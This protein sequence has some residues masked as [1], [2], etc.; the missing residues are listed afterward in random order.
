MSSTTHGSSTKTLHTMSA[1][2]LLGEV[3]IVS[4]RASSSNKEVDIKITFGGGYKSH[5]KSSYTNYSYSVD[6]KIDGFSTRSLT[7]YSGTSGSTMTTS[8]W[9]DTG[10]SGSLPKS[11]TTVYTYKSASTTVTSSGWTSGSKSVSVIFYESG[12][13]VASSTFDLT[14]PT[15]S[16]S[17]GGGG[18]TT[19][20]ANTMSISISPSSVSLGNSATISITS[21]AGTRNGISKYIIYEGS[22]QLGS[23]TSTTYTVTPSST[24]TKTYKVKAV[25]TV[26]TSYDI[27]KSINLSVTT[28]N[29]SPI[30]YLSVGSVDG[31]ISGA[32]DV[33]VYVTK[34]STYWAYSVGSSSGAKTVVTSRNYS[35]ITA[36]ANQTIYVYGCELVNGTY[37]YST[38]V[39]GKVGVTYYVTDV[40]STIAPKILKDNISSPDLVTLIQR[41]QASAR[42]GGG[43]LSYTWEYAQSSTSSGLSNPT[44]LDLGV[45][46]SSFTNLDMTQK[47]NKGY[48]YKIRVKATNSYDN[49]EYSSDS[50]IYQIP[51]E[52]SR[53]TF[54][55]II[56]K[57][58]PSKGYTEI[59]QDNKKFYGSGLFILWTNPTILDSQLPISEIEMIYQSKSQS[60]TIYDE[61]KTAQFQYHKLLEEGKTEPEYYPLSNASGASNGGG[62]DLEV[63]SLYETK[64][65]IRITDTLGQ[66]IDTFYTTETFFK[67]ESPSFG[68]NL[69]VSLNDTGNPKDTVATFRPFTC[70][71]SKS[72][73]LSSSVAQSNSQ[74]SLLYFIDCYVNDRKT[75]I[76]LLDGIPIATSAFTDD[77]KPSGEILYS[78]E[79]IKIKKYNSTTI[80]YEINNSYFKNKLLSSAELRTPKNNSAAVYNDDFLEVIY[81]ISV[82]DDFDSRSTVY[83][84]ANTNIKYIEAPTLSNNSYLDIGVN[85]YIKSQNPF[86]DNSIVLLNSSSNNNDRMIN[87]GESIIFK[88]KRAQDYNG[89]DYSSTMLGD[90]TQYNIYVSRNDSIVTSNYENLTYTLLKSFSA[91]NNL[92]KAY[93]ND[94]TDEYYYLEY[95]LTN[96]MESK[97]VV[98][99]IE[100]VDSKSQKSD[101]LYSNTYIVPCRASSMDFYLSN[102]K[103][104]E[105]L[106]G[107]DLTFK[108]KV[109]DFG[110][111]FFVN[112][113]YGY[114]KTNKNYSFPNYERSFTVNSNTFS[115]K[116]YLIFEGCLDGDFSN[117]GTT[118]IKSTGENNTEIDNLYNNYFS[119]TIDLTSFLTNE[120][121]YTDIIENTYSASDFPTEWQTGIKNSIIKKIFFRLTYKIAYGFADIE[122]DTFD[123]RYLFVS[124]TCAPYS[125]YEDAPTVS[126][127]NHQ[128]GINT[129]DFSIDSEGGQKEVLIIQDNGSYNLVVFKGAEQKII[130]NLTERTFYTEDN[131]G[132]V[133]TEI[134]FNTQYINGMTIDSGEW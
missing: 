63:N 68:G 79:N 23:T 37:Y 120:N 99:K 125:Y 129:K 73:L 13:Q 39:N 121:C 115:R 19:I 103:L 130:L 8:S 131:S 61:I 77:T 41:G 10:S 108:S 59:I 1:N 116:G 97:F 87:P 127:R 4:T 95:P 69:V 78:D 34:S 32:Q 58:D 90:V 40:S 132:K 91:L 54:T 83:N 74:D 111:S 100:A 66:Y 11:G 85:R 110:A 75:T 106:T 94:S 114:D 62:A 43:S 33:F 124:S 47:V 30:S 17:G 42:T 31:S 53:P 93:P 20:G 89:A 49:Y 113:L 134:N 15:Y 55:K 86:Y 64:V 38:P 29:V 60:A 52:P 5:N 2:T 25:S 45:S 109:S 84:S 126:Y 72:F 67:A 27:T 21:K 117:N 57:A 22:T 104:N 6:V 112:N 123:T 14:C 12:N 51:R 46:G 76:H 105:T 119:Q 44:W 16:S 35:Y 24:G 81:K 9:K 101:F 133:L 80:H 88:F 56:A 65:G 118:I 48:Y 71:T 122:S 92:K 128:V 18:S 107:Y 26:G 82:K 28:P 70:D 96:Y 50:E 98:F 7:I 3:K 102:V 36:S